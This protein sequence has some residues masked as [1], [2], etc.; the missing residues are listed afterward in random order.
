M[1]SLVCE[2]CFGDVPETGRVTRALRR[3]EAVLCWVCY[4][5]KVSADLAQPER[6]TT[7]EKEA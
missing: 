4:R 3:G 6:M 7:A 1:D 2:A 5:L